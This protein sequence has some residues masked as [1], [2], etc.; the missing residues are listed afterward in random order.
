VSD[1]YARKGRCSARGCGVTIARAAVAYVAV[2]LLPK[3]FDDDELLHVGFPMYG[4][5]RIKSR[6]LDYE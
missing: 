3:L 4:R 6:L 1:L 5:T 2:A